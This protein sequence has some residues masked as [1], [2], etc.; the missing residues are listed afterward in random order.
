MSKVKVKRK[1]PGRN[2]GKRYA[3]PLSLFPLTITQAIRAIATT[4]KNGSNGARR[5]SRDGQ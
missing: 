4:G 5:R 2:K 1:M 3:K